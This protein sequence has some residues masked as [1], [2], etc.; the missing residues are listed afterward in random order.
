MTGSGGRLVVK[1][2]HI[3]IYIYIIIIIII[4]F[5]FI[6]IYSILGGVKGALQIGFY[7]LTYLLLLLALAF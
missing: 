3:Y 4:Y 1:H 6:I 7:L 2:W 5:F